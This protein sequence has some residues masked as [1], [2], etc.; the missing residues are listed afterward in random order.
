MRIKLGSPLLLRTVADMCG[1]LLV[2]SENNN[3]FQAITHLAT[4]SRDVLPGDMFVALKTNKDD[5]H[6]YIE[7]A[8]QQG[9]SVV[10]CHHAYA[11]YAAAACRLLTDDTFSA[12]ARFSGKYADTIPHK[13]IAITGSVGKTSTR[14]FI[15]SVLS[16]EYRVHES[17]HNYNNLLGVCILLLTMPRATEFLIA[18]CG[19]GGPGEI[20]PLSNLLKPDYAIITNIGISHIENF[21][22]KEAIL[23]EKIKITEGNQNCRLLCGEKP[24]CLHPHKAKETFCISVHDQSADCCCD[25]IQDNI[26]GITFSCHVKGHIIEHL[27][28]PTIGIHTLSC[29]VFSV[30]LGH[31]LGICDDEIRRGLAAY[32]EEPLRQSV[33][34]NGS[35]TLLADAYNACPASMCAAIDTT[36]A[37]MQYKNGGSIIVLGDMYELGAMTAE[38]HRYIGAVAAKIHPHHLIFWGEYG[39]HYLAGALSEDYP[40]EKILC[41]TKDTPPHVV[42]DAVLKQMLPFDTVLFKG[43]RQMKM[44]KLLPYLQQNQV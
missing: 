33:I 10:L 15:S 18:E 26:Y 19:T 37:L 29:A 35:I 36:H 12:L 41:F 13:T 11:G 44:E 32:R 14:R 17:P 1:A 2:M 39:N 38:R 5:G 28:I 7:N 4:D 23:N 34:H 9:A 22:S 30:F 3:C 40:K 43:S 24:C 25:N 8:V 42:A 16:T 31:M 27:H 20:A 21:K 6:H